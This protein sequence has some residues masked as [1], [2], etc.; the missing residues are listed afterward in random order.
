MS[1]SVIAIQI[2]LSSALFLRATDVQRR[3]HNNSCFPSVSPRELNS[4]SQSQSCEQIFTDHINMGPTV[5]SAFAFALFMLDNTAEAAAT[6]GFFLTY[7]ISFDVRY[8][9]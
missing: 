9:E 3:V 2:N 1:F 4:Q 7:C 6:N 8:E 5:A